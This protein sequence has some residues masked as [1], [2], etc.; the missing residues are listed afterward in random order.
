MLA[1]CLALAACQPSRPKTA[2]DEESALREAGYARAP[3]ITGV[4]QSDP[5][6][7]VVTGL[8][9]QNGRVRVVYQSSHSVGVTADSK[10][11]FRADVPAA[12][13]GGIYDLSMDD[14]GRS[15]HAD[16]RLFVPQG[17]PEK[18]VLLRSG[19]PSQSLLNANTVVAVID[20]GGN[21]GAAVTG[22]VAPNSDVK[23]FEGTDL[24]GQA[25]SDAQGNY[26]ITTRIL[27]PTETPATWS[28]TV[29]TGNA[30][31]NENVVVSLP[32][33]A[34]RDQISAVDDG[35]RVDWVLPGGGMQS[36]FVF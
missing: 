19:T 33:S 21:G 9:T 24:R 6:T 12:A 18:A 26:S 13:P 30:S 20:I 29:Q 25:R 5:S 10:G 3:V 1:S 36:S 16:G 11:R 2:D 17:H 32:N 15:M 23:I 28:F 14:N 7:F 34:A 4:N 27:P 22:R 35:W 31:L 8:A